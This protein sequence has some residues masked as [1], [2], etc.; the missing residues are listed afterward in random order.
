MTTY[1]D[2][3]SICLDDFE[4]NNTNTTSLKCGHTFHVN[5]IISSLRKSNECP[6]CRDTDG[7]PKLSVETHNNFNFLW[8][9]GDDDDQTDEYD[10]YSEEYTDF[11]NVMKELIKNNKEIKDKIN[12]YKTNYKLFEKEIANIDKKYSTGLNE[13]TNNYLV[14]FRNCVEF[15]NY[16]KERLKFQNKYNYL[17]KTIETSLSKNLDME[18]DQTIKDYIKYYLEAHI[19]EIYYFTLPR[20]ISL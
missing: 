18:T 2:T 16:N 4:T 3:C 7:N 13:L 5:C 12:N 9:D 8:D 11:E 14:S 10:T 1:N 17:R 6:N 15:Q 20:N 19:G